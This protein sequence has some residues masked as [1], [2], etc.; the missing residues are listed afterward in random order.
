MISFAA[1]SRHNSRRPGLQMLARPR[2]RPRYNRHEAR[3]GIVVLTSCCLVR[4][5]NGGLGPPDLDLQRARSEI[6]AAVPLWR[7]ALAR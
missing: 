4:L 6:F 3:A 5:S 2:H 1:R 7:A